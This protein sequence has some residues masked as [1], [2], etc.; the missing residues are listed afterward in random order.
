MTDEE[1]TI[2]PG[3]EDEIL[4]PNTG[5]GGEKLKADDDEEKSFNQE[6]VNE[7]VVERLKRAEEKFIENLGLK[8]KEE[9]VEY[10]K[11]AT[12]YDT[13]KNEYEKVSAENFALKETLAFQKHNIDKR[14][15]EDIRIYFK[16]KELSFSEETL[17]EELVSHPEWCKKEV[18]TI[19]T[20]SPEKNESKK[21]DDEERFK[22][23]Y[24]I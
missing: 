24:G 7:I 11:K 16:G 20:L 4:V 18:S 21:E 19:K 3:T 22:K 10:S 2:I 14:R 23:T 17:A 5:E 1:K 15:E 12:D 6:E 8:T 9:L 13:I